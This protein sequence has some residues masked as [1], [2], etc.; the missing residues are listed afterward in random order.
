[1]RVARAG[2]CM[3]LRAAITATAFAMAARDCTRSPPGTANCRARCRWLPAPPRRRAPSFAYE[4]SGLPADYRGCLLVTSWG[5]HVVERFDLTPRGASFAREVVV[6]LRG[7]EDFRPVALAVAPDGSLVL[8]DWVDRSYPVHGKGRIW[9]VRSKKPL[10]DDGLRPARVAS[11]KIAKLRSLLRDPRREIRAAAGAAL[12][13]K[14]REGRAALAAVLREEKDVRARIQALWSVA[15]LE[16][17]VAVE[18]LSSA[19]SDTAPEVR[20]EAAHLL[21]DVLPVEVAQRDE[22]RLLELA[23]KDRSAFVRRQ[24]LSGLR[25]PAA[26]RAIVPTLADA[27][28]FL[29][30]TALAVL[31]RPGGSAL[32]LPHIKEKNPALRLGVLLALR[33]SGDAAGRDALPA[34]LADAD[35]GVRRAAVQWI[36]EERLRR[37]AAPMETA[38]ARCR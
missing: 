13:D 38:V 31:G 35:P 16:P 5:D 32:L 4:S 29:V 12:A 7:G 1:M 23:T 17:V 37:F 36:G 28:P 2:W 25:T 14:G 15:N 20:G 8:S 18:L 22:E 30:G 19:L 6:L 11:L 21:G 34:F 26:L 9:R 24:A 33:R 27:D 10:A 3:S